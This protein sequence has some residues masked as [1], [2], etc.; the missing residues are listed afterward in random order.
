LLLAHCFSFC[1]GNEQQGQA[2]LAATTPVDYALKV[3]AAFMSAFLLLAHCFSFCRGN[4]QQ[5][6]TLP[7]HLWTM[8]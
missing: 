5:G 4:E 6:Q 3:C 7:P 2:A 1:R 8:P